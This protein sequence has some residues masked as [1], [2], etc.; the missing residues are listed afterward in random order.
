MHECD[1]VVYIIDDD[2]EARRSMEALVQSMKLRSQLYE[3]AESFLEDHDDSWCGC[4]IVDMCLPEMS[5]HELLTR[6]VEANS[7]LSVIMISAFGTIPHA[8][9]AMKTGALDFVEKPYNSDK[10]EKAISNGLEA[11]RARCSERTASDRFRNRLKSLTPREVTVLL[12]VLADKP[13][14]SIA[15]GLSVSLRTA[16]RLR[17]TVYDK[18]GVIS[19]TDLARIVAKHGLP[20]DLER[21]EKGDPP[22]SFSGTA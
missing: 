7:K 15:K 18:L 20:E 9:R 16:A 8:V 5:G 10:L 2:Q 19:A 13:N 22:Q 12:D 14:R 1:E 6:L 17:A 3:S 4:V 11:S 21:L